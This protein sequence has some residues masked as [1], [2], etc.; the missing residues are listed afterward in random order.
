MADNVAITAGSGTT[1]ASDDVGGVQFQRVKPSVGVDGSAT[2]V[3]DVAPIP[4]KLMGVATGSGLTPYALKSANTTNLTSVKAS[5]GA[6]S[7]IYAHLT[8]ATTRFLK[9]YDKA[10][11]P[12]PATDTPVAVFPLAQNVPLN[13]DLGG[14][15][16]N[17]TNGIAF[18]ITGAVGDTDTTA[19]STNEVLVNML[20]K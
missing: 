12:D 5:A 18:S 19:V 14:L 3:S 1:I 20:Y 10:S 6:I 17:F 4:A 15:Q 11:A 9:L 7:K 2:D 13:F 16:W 8:G